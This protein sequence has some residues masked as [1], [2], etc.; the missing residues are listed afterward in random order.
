MDNLVKQICDW[1]DVNRQFSL[2]YL[3]QVLQEK[4]ISLHDK[5]MD[6]RMICEFVSFIGFSPTY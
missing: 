4:K 5:I 3:S 6:T 1:H 2:G